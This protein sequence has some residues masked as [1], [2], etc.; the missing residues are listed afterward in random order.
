MPRHQRILSENG[1]YHVM[2][3]GNERKNLFLDEEDKQKFI[4]ILNTK[5]EETGF[6]IFAYCLMDNHVHLLVRESIEGLAT[7]MKRINVSYVYYFNQKNRRTGH[8][9]Q[10]RFKS[11]PI[12]EERYLLSVLRYIHNNPLKAGMVEKPEQYKWS[13][14]GSYL[15]PHR[16]EAKMVDTAFILSLMAND[17]KKAIQ[18]FKKFSIEKDESEFLDIEEGNIWTIE[19]AKSYLE[20]YLTKRWRGKSIEELM[21]HK[22]SRREI[23][24]ELKTNTRLSV[25]AIANLLGLNRGIVQK[26]R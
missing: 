3:R 4:E 17:Q 24:I 21:D 7:I 13:S 12:D 22:D 25:R 19:E 9:F 18:E 20:E 23:I 10:D 16:P 11:E 14:Y 15:N 8:L 2:I 6:L 26:M 5:K 1:T